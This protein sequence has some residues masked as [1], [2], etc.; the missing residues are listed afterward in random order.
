MSDKGMEREPVPL[1][2]SAEEWAM[3]VEVAS[4]QGLTLQQHLANTTVRPVSSIALANA[5]LKADDPR[6][7]TRAMVN[8]LRDVAET[9]EAES[10]EDWHED[11]APLR[12]MA[13]ALAS[14]L[15]PE[16]L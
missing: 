10:G 4:D 15:P 12:A 11:V 9:H 1:A 13:D 16:E 7:I 3:H 5:A 8:L 14:Y 6:K 2:L